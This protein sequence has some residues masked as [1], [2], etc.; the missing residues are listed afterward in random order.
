MSTYDK[1][2]GTNWLTPLMGGVL[3][4]FV[5]LLPLMAGGDLGLFTLL[6]AVV[7]VAF[8]IYGLVKRDRVV[9]RR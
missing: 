4:L 2:P 3:L 8:V 9:S 1:G 6:A 5:G 7:G